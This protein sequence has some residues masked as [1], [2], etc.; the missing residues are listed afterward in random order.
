MT[1]SLPV[2]KDLLVEENFFHAL[3]SWSRYGYGVRIRSY[4]FSKDKLQKWF[5]DNKLN[6]MISR[7]QDIILRTDLDDLKFSLVFK[8][9]YMISRCQRR[10]LLFLPGFLSTDCNKKKLYN[11]KILFLKT[12]SG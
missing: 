3:E 7:Y 11:Q 1:V 5:W 2:I 6:L 4:G 9:N 8:N 12:F 10:S